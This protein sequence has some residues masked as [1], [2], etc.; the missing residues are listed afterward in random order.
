MERERRE[1]GFKGNGWFF[2]AIGIDGVLGL[3][4]AN[5]IKQ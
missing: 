5:L 3:D 1:T 4:F 2:S